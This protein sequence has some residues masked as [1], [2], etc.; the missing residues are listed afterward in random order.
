MRS[1]AGILWAAALSALLSVP[2]VSMAGCGGGSAEAA[3]E[4][5]SDEVATSGDEDMG[6]TETEAVADEPAPAPPSGP[7]RLRAVNRVGGADVGGTVRVLNEAGEVVREGA[8]GDTFDV[9]SGDYTVEGT[10]TDAA[11]LVDRPTRSADGGATVTPGETAT[12]QINFPVSRIRIE[13]RRHG[14]VVRTWRLTVHPQGAEEPEITLE[15][16]RDHVPITP[17]RYEGSLRAG[18]NEIAVSGLIFQ[19]GAT[20]S[21]PINMD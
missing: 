12:A 20:M 9:P 5:G 11:I 16:T 21:V 3:D 18:S 17:G 7:G 4:S 14:T 10:I 15:P 19:G 2:L 1:M 6:D 8:S 13:V